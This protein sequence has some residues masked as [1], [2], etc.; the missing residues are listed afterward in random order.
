M[1]IASLTLAS[2]PSEMRSVSMPLTS[3]LSRPPSR[4]HDTLIFS[5]IFAWMLQKRIEINI[6]IIR[7]YD[8]VRSVNVTMNRQLN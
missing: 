4:L 8:T 1:W 2:S 6:G 5:S 3:M 7:Y